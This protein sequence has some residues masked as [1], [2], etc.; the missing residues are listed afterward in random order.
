LISSSI[1]VAEI[2]SGQFW[3]ATGR[4]SLSCDEATEGAEGEMDVSAVCDGG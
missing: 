3:L 1:V 4:G 2:N